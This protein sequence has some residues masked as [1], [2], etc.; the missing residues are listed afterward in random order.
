MMINL[1]NLINFLKDGVIKNTT[2]EKCY[3]FLLIEKIH[4]SKS[5]DK[6]FNILFFI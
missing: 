3:D 5:F 6:R 1:C 4:T 2:H